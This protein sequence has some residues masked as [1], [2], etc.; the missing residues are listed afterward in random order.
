MSVYAIIS[1]IAS[2]TALIFGTT[3][4]TKN[5]KNSRNILFFILSVIGCSTA[6]FEYKLRSSELLESAY[7]WYKLL[8]IWPLTVSFA[9]H[10]AAD[11]SGYIKRISLKIITGLIH[12]TAVYFCFIQIAS[13]RISIE[14]REIYWGWKIITKGTISDDFIAIWVLTVFIGTLYILFR[15]YLNS[16]EGVV[17]NHAKYLFIGFFISYL[18][19]FTTDIISSLTKINLPGFGNSSIILCNAFIGYAMFKYKL[20]VLNPSD[21]ANQIIETMTASL[22]LTNS[23]GQIVFVNNRTIDLFGTNYNKLIDSPISILFKNESLQSESDI[24]MNNLKFNEDFIKK[25][26]KVLHLTVNR[27]CIRDQ[28]K[29][30]QGYV[31]L[32]DD[33]GDIK[34]LED[35]KEKV[36]QSDRLKS[37]FIRLFY[38]E[39]RKPLNTIL[40]SSQRLIGSNSDNNDRKNVINSVNEKGKNLNSLI[41]KTLELIKI[42]NNQIKLKQ[43][44]VNIN[45][46]LD[47]IKESSINRIDKK[48]VRFYTIKTF[49]DNQ[50]LIYTD[51]VKLEK[52]LELIV[53][54]V[55]S[56]TDRGIIKLGYLLSN[57]STIEFY[58]SSD[59]Y[60]NSNKSDNNAIN[61][62]NKY[63]NLQLRIL[64]STGMSL[65]IVKSYIELMNGKCWSELDENILNIYLSFPYNQYRKTN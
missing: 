37:D 19:A 46:I 65:A 13:N 45:H 11:F 36:L 60:Y 30:P 35:E 27:I 9:F 18:T 50:D 32:A 54:I 51:N 29:N 33:I 15:I 49:K 61:N 25:D 3:I 24:V 4:I 63:N 8:G 42:E 6:F 21:T 38:E 14:L 52:M 58:V 57:D 62:I 31:Y 55:C 20:F 59:H 40:S 47:H 16:K 5:P 34:H 26:K 44:V 22:I 28:H 12:L 43:N 7:F 1:L 17:K 10:F 56:H 41:N 23:K 2:L 39:I 48:R 53:E 64:G